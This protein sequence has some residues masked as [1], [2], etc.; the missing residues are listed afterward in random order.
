MVISHKAPFKAC[1]STA[2]ICQIMS[3]LWGLGLI[4]RS[5]L[6]CS[7]AC[8]DCVQAQSIMALSSN[9]DASPESA[10]F[11][12]NYGLST[13]W[14]ALGISVVVNLLL[15]SIIVNFKPKPTR[16]TSQEGGYKGVTG[17]D[18]QKTWL[19][20]NLTLVF[21][22]LINKRTGCLHKIIT[23]FIINCTKCQ[24]NIFFRPQDSV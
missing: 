2:L 24:K 14:S 6:Y 19:Q 16:Q 20:S 4:W 18:M 8:P 17:F 13:V 1:I 5:F 22:I 11:F 12:G 7:G 9:S 3:Y 15:L 21:I 10:E 23:L